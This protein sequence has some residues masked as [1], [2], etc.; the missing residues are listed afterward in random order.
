[1]GV[2]LQESES[3]TPQVNVDLSE[4]QRWWPEYLKLTSKT[5]EEA[6]YNKAFDAVRTAFKT[7]YKAEKSTVVDALNAMSSKYPARTV[8]E[9]LVIVAAR[10]R[11]QEIDDLKQE[12][13]KFIKRRGA[14]VGFV[15]SGWI[16]PMVKLMPYIGKGSLSVNTSIRNYQGLGG[17]SVKKG[18][19]EVSVT[20]WNDVIGKDHEAKVEHY[21]VEAA[22]QG[23]D[24]ITKDMV[25]YIERKLEHGE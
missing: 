18:G 25:Q 9:M 1:M 6:T 15:K 24:F 2:Y 3:M 19:G 16:E 5:V 14:A 20:A 12:A 13:A 4:F 21:K 7:N 23:I 8:A 11:G 10:N 17:A 22:Q